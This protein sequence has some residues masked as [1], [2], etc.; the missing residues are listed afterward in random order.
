MSVL[1]VPLQSPQINTV[2][3]LA[4]DSRP[5]SSFS[6]TLFL[7]ANQSQDPNVQSIAQTYI[8]HYNLDEAIKNCSESKVIMCESKSSLDYIIRF[9][10]LNFKSKEHDEFFPDLSLPKMVRPTCT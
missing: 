9:K 2:T 5:I 7:L 3:E 4:K 6:D 1:T 10:I 8:V